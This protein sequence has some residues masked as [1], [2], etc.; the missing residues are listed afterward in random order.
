MKEEPLLDQELPRLRVPVTGH[1][2]AVATGGDDS[3]INW[4]D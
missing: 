2:V 4:G 1:I 3:E